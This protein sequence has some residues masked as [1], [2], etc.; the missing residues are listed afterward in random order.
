MR[1][2]TKKNDLLKGL[3][4]VQGVVEKKDTANLIERTSRD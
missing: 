4:L 1:I 2:T 3:T